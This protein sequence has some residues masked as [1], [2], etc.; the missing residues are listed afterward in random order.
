VVGEQVYYIKTRAEGAP[1]YFIHFLLYQT[2]LTSIFYYLQVFYYSRIQ[3]ASATP[4]HLAKTSDGVLKSKHF[5]GVALILRITI[6][7]FFCVVK[8]QLCFFGKY[9]R[10]IPFRFSMLPFS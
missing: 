7:I 9:L 1:H 2:I 5:I 8:R 10:D 4:P 3:P 6:S